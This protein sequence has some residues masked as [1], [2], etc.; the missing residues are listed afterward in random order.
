MKG[1]SSS[2]G[3]ALEFLNL[4]QPSLW[5]TLTSVLQLVLRKAFN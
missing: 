1:T 3:L 2:G 4:K 5:K